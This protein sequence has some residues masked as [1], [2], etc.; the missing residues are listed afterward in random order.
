MTKQ[1]QGFFPFVAQ[2]QN[3]DLKRYS[4]ADSALRVPVVF[5]NGISPGVLCSDPK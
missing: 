4:D 1:I 2:G 3:D 5:A